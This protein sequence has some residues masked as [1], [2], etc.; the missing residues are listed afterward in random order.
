MAG[1]GFGLKKVFRGSGVFAVLRGYSLAAVVTEGPM[2]LMILLLFALRH[3]LARFGTV[4]R[5]QEQFL[6]FMTYATIFSLLL[7]DTVLL[8]LDRFIS[9]C[10]YQ[11]RL[12]E[13]LPSF[14]G[15]T[16]FLLLAGAPAMGLYLLTLPVGWDVRLAVQLL[17]CTLLI[18]WVQMSYLS[19]IKRYEYVLLGFA[20]GAASALALTWC[21]LAGGM[22][23]LSA[24]LWGTAL[25]FLVLLFLY[26]RQLLTC[27][28]A[29][30]WNLPAF[31]PTLQRYPGLL[32][33]GL[34]LGLEIGRAHV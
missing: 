6:F 17:F 16:F 23:P 32:L 19:A 10:I 34:L 11:Q 8:F 22:Q 24:A 15:M 18:V 30:E 1:I 14:F 29:G 3:L 13:I 5:L 25:G 2:V 4:Y 33:T 9:D 31:F 20:A 7:A 21:F 12:Q 26:M 28:P 27:Y